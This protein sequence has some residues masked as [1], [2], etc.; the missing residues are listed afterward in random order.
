VQVDNRKIE[1]ANFFREWKEGMSFYRQNRL[2]LTLLISA[3]IVT[4]GTGAFDA[5]MVFFFQKNLHA[6]DS[7]FGTLPMA[8]GAGSVLG[9]LLAALL[10]KR[11]G[12]ACLFWLS[13]YVVG[14]VVILFAR[15]SVLWLALALLCLAGLPLGALNAALG[16]LLMHIIP[17]EI[18]GRVMSV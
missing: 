12:S 9:A 11:L 15:Q 7:L 18:M 1:Q 16:P 17:H 10:V 5:L 3:L 4:L 8:V 14:I 6:P 2:M 13:L